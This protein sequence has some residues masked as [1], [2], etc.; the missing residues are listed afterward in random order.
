MTHVTFEN[1]S[2]NNSVIINTKGL[3]TIQ[4]C[5]VHAWID[6]YIHKSQHEADFTYKTAEKIPSVINN[7]TIYFINTSFHEWLEMYL[8]SGI[9]TINIVNCE[10]V[11]YL[12]FVTGNKST[13]TETRHLRVLN[14]NIINTRF[15]NYYTY[16]WPDGRDS[17][18]SLKVMNSVFNSSYMVQ[19]KGAGYFSAVLEDSKFHKSEI[20]FEQEMSVI[21]QNCKYDVGDNRYS[22]NL[23]MI[24]NDHLTY[25]P[26]GIQ[27]AIK[28]LICHELQCEN[29]LSTVSIENTVFTGIL[30]KQT[31]SVTKINDANLIMR[32]VTFNIYLEDVNIR[33]WYISYKSLWPDTI[34]ELTNVA[35][36][37][38]SMPSSAPISM[39]SSTKLDVKNFQIFCPQSLTVVNITTTI[40]EQF[41]CEKQCPTDTYTFQ[42]GT[43]VINGNKHYI[44][45]PYNITYNKSNVY[46]K[47]CPLGANCT[48]SIKALPMYWGYKNSLED[49]VT[50]IRCPNGYCCNGTDMCNGMHSCNKNR[51]GSICGECQNGFSEAL[52]S[53]ECLLGDTCMGNIVLLYYT[54]CVTIYILFLAT[55]KDLQKCL[56]AKITELYKRIKNHLCSK[57]SN[58][59]STGHNQ[60]GLSKIKKIDKISEID[61]PHD[62]N[63]ESDKV[64]DNSKYIQILFFYIQ[65]AIPF[66]INIPGI[67][68]KEKGAIAKIMSFSPEMFTL[69]YTKVIHTCFSYVKTSVSKVIFEMLFVLYL[70]VI[71]SL[72]YMIQKIISKFLKKTSNFWAKVKSC[73]LKAFLLGVLFSYQNLVMGAFTLVRCVDVAN[74][75]VLHIQ[76]DI[77]C[78]NW[79]QYIVMCCIIFFVIPFFL[80]VSF[81]PYYIKD[82]LM[83]VKTFIV[84]CLIPGP[85]IMYHVI[86]NIGKKI[87]SLYTRKL[88]TETIPIEI[89]ES[90][91]E[92]L[93]TQVS[94]DAYSGPEGLDIP[95]IDENYDY[96]INT[97]SISCE[98]NIESSSNGR[99]NI[100]CDLPIRYVR[101]ISYSKSEKEILTTLLEHYKELNLFG[102]RFTWLCIHKLYRVTLVACN[103]FITEPIY[104]L[105]LMTLALMTVAIANNLVRPYNDYKA[106]CTASFSYAANLCL[107]MLNLFK[108]GLVTFDCR[109]NCSFQR[110][111]LWYFDLVENVLLSNLPC[112]SIVAWFVYTVAQK[113]SP[114]KEKD[115]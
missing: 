38:T 22:D 3:I 6:F 12:I 61:V 88:L 25:E 86:I 13:K 11:N 1:I 47:V 34:V 40:E 10:F 100:Q 104:R 35:I 51:T 82:K 46:C 80:I 114:K 66:K 76:G 5:T 19:F 75:T 43:A 113:C 63:K 59:N 67:S 102:M 98:S 107:A 94:T 106:N 83:S 49:S 69:I 105:C 29:Y 9:R 28:L 91:K 36:N 74:I 31:D 26:V 93:D 96:D 7:R 17:I 45:S 90:E 72:L 55:Y 52:F 87:N 4:G 41:Y 33:R 15:T 14:I 109:S 32:N 2:F 30:N 97:D 81:F 65:D 60:N 68:T 42:A 53:T 16:Y 92:S 50:M 48:G 84:S 79:W 111:V 8:L 57:E 85:F 21:M 23:N 18:I 77:Q 20:R 78:Y 39:V 58:F 24:G 95:F 27:K 99:I 110:T 112:L 73:L 44:N 64:D 56:T 108:T 54:V 89:L 71:T 62:E 101:T 115:K 103:A 37:A 70:I